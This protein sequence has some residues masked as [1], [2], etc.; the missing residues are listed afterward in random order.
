MAYITC[1]LYQKLKK[2]IPSDVWSGKENHDDLRYKLQVAEIDVR[3]RYNSK[4]SLY[5]A[6]APTNFL[7]RN[8]DS[9]WY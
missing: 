3:K 4:L 9:Y 7:G 6:L 8:V 5:V 1:G 2:D